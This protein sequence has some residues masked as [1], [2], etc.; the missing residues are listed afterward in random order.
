MLLEKVDDLVPFGELWGGNFK[1][2]Q[3]FVKINAYLDSLRLSR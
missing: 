3:L 1:S 2:R